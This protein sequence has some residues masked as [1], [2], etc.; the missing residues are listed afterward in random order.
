MTGV[1]LPEDSPVSVLYQN[2][3]RASV[4]N[5]T[6]VGMSILGACQQTANDLGLVAPPRIIIHELFYSA[7]LCITELWKFSGFKP[8]GSYGD[9]PS[10]VATKCALSLGGPGRYVERIVELLM[11]EL[12]DVFPQGVEDELPQFVDRHLH[13]TTSHDRILGC[14]LPL[15]NVDTALDP[16][17]SLTVCSFSMEEFLCDLNRNVM[18][19]E[20][21]Q[22]LL[23][24]P[25]VQLPPTLLRES[26]EQAGIRIPSPDI[27]ACIV[28]DLCVSTIEAEGDDITVEDKQQ[29][30]L[31][32]IGEYADAYGSLCDDHLPFALPGFRALDQYHEVNQTQI[33][34]VLP[35]AAEANGGGSLL[36]KSAHKTP[37]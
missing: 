12:P 17:V 10:D 7:A 24:N 8:R 2:L 31:E 4:D 13:S 6:G 14:I 3:L 25:S 29:I 32:Q 15:D 5:E 28:V 16:E 21:I 1:G 22:Q 37:M 18:G 35:L 23:A 11:K 26:L 33:D 36:V 34:S 30:V 27:I 20:H 19:T 9:P